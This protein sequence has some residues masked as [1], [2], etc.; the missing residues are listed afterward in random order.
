MKPRRKKLTEQESE[1]IGKLAAA[2]YSKAEVKRILG[3]WGKVAD[4]AYTAARVE[5][6]AGV[7]SAVYDMALAGSAPAQQIYLDLAKRR[8]RHRGDETRAELEGR[9]E[10]ARMR[11]VG[12]SHADLAS[13][14]AGIMED[15]S[16]QDPL[17]LKYLGL[18]QGALDK[19]EARETGALTVQVVVVRSEDDIP[20]PPLPPGAEATNAD[21]EG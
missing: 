16:P 8:P 4:D 6:E 15:L 14:I 5:A 1:L 20:P 21:P 12:Y 10:M 9:M 3:W 17:H 7:R 13:Y 11:T 2:Q 18:Y 19:S